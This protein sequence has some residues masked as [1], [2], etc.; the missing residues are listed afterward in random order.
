MAGNALHTHYIDEGAISASA[1]I[2]MQ[3]IANVIARENHR[4]IAHYL[5]NLFNY[6]TGKKILAQYLA[7]VFITPE[8]AVR[9]L[10]KNNS[11]RHAQRWD[12]DI[13]SPIPAEVPYI[14]KEDEEIAREKWM[15]AENDAVRRAEEIT[16]MMKQILEKTGI[17]P[18]L[19][20]EVR[21]PDIA[22]ITR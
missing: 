18:P 17:E 9:F 8:E 5:N 10:S 15:R 7:L 2:V 22:P 13:L 16:A 11:P 20:L 3:D 6:H 14:P 19:S 4:P 21:I 12:D 1:E